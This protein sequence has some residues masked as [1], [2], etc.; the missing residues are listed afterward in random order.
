MLE[1]DLS[2]YQPSEAA[3][4]VLTQSRI[5]DSDERPK[6]MLNRVIKTLFGIESRFG[7]PVG[8]VENLMSRFAEYMTDKA[9]SPGSPILT[10]AGRPEYRNSGLSSCV[11]VPVDLERKSEAAERIKS[12]YR[13]N[14]GSGFDFT[15]Y[16]DPVGLLIWL[17]QLSADE[18][19]TGLYDRYIGNMGSLHVS[20]PKI[21]EFVGA[22]R[23]RDLRHFNISIDV[24]EEFMEAAI[25]RKE[26]R[27]TDRTRVN[28]HELLAE[29]A[30]SAWYNGDPGIIYL[31]RMNR[32]NP[33]SEMSIYTSTPPCAEMGLAPGETCQFGYLNLVKFA[34][35]K[36]IDYTRLAE[37][38]RLMTRALDN[39]IEISLNNYPDPQSTVMA[40]LKRKIGISVCGLADLF[41]VYDLPYDSEGARQLAR[42]VLAFINYTS[43]LTSVRLAEE[44]GSCEAMRYYDKNKYLSGRYLEEKYAVCETKTVSLEE[45]LALADY[46]RRTGNLRNILTT[47]LPPSGRTSILMGATPSI[48]PIFG[49]P[50]WDSSLRLVVI[51]FIAR[52]ADGYKAQDILSQAIVDG[53]FQ[54]TALTNE[55]RVCLKTAKEISYKDQMR[56]VAALV[57]LHGVFDESASKTV[58]LPNNATVD[59]VLKVYI[60]AHRLGLKNISVYRDGSK[61]GQPTWL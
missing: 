23:E 11:L 1:R 41:L 4:K 48:E 37:G 17:N 35:P 18:T 21:R 27:L 15:P 12:Y 54:T 40:R 39:A 44:R 55:A 47:A 2:F 14:M 16:E 53:T 58:T 30:W 60:L 32:D 25:A 20:H 31:E 36:G 52:Y 43:K 10:N 51:D 13:Q 61:D 6:E 29:I 3:Y 5:L 7:T 45:W 46:I 49:V 42:D 19:A 59:D 26:Y 57:G 50:D 34:T 24:T 28:A 56:M 22:K 33:I 8:Q 9:M 38:T